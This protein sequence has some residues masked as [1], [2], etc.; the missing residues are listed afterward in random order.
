MAGAKAGLKTEAGGDE[1]K[2]GGGKRGDKLRDNIIRARAGRASRT[3]KDVEGA[4]AH[5]EPSALGQGCDL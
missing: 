5:R 3:D 4:L 2:H 1:R